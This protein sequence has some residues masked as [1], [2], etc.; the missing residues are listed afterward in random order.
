MRLAVAVTGFSLAGGAVSAIVRGAPAQERLFACVAFGP[1]GAPPSRTRRLSAPVTPRY[2]GG[3]P[4]E[5]AHPLD[6]ERPVS[7]VQ[8]W[9]FPAM[10][11]VYLAYWWAIAPRVKETERREPAPSRI[12]RALLIL[13][14]L[15]LVAVPRLPL[16]VLGSRFLPGGPA[17]FWAGAVVTAGGLSFSVWARR[18]L[19]RNWSQA[20]TLKA[21]H[22]LVTGGPYAV[23]RHPIYTG[24][25]LAFVGCALAVGEL[26][27]LLAVGLVLIALWRKLRLEDEWLATE[28]GTLTGPM[29]AASPRSSPG[30]CD[31]A[32][33]RAMAR[34]PI[35]RGRPTSS[36]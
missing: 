27:G 11:T 26:R 28:F 1:L 8:A 34:R 13:T 32:G 36:R 2:L 31:G 10:G 4:P 17:S 22:E 35:A 21:D 29:P 25:L 15:A 3:T 23:V 20:V 24:L 12:L 5:N 33:R 9:L 14:A 16:P 7:I 19:G 18:H 6:E 30:S